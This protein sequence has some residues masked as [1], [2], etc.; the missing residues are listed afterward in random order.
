[1][2]WKFWTEMELWWLDV[3]LDGPGDLV[4]WML[5]AAIILLLVAILAIKVAFW[6]GRME[7]A[8]HV[9]SSPVF[10]TRPMWSTFLGV[11]VAVVLSG[12]VLLLGSMLFGGEIPP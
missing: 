6:K 4:S 12:V 11:I 10:M 2:M 7:F 3:Q 5:G 9:L 1:M 8:E